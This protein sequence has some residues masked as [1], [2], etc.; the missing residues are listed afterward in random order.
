[1]PFTVHNFI[2]KARDSG[3]RGVIPSRNAELDSGNGEVWL[4]SVH[5]A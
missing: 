2:G 5:A 4:S 3:K 1:M